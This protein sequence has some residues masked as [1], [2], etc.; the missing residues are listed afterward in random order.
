MRPAAEKE[1]LSS[2]PF[3][4]GQS[5]SLKRHLTCPPPARVSETEI[6]G[7]SA[8]GPAEIPAFLSHAML[9]RTSAS[10]L[11]LGL[12]A[13]L[14]A[15]SSEK[16]EDAPD[17]SLP[18]LVLP[19]GGC[20]PRALCPDEFECG[21][22]DDGCGGKLSCG[23]CGG[24]RECSEH[25]CSECV[26][27]TTCESEGR[28]CGKLT[29]ECGDT[30]D[31]GGCDTGE[32]CSGSG[33]ACE[34]CTPLECGSL[35]A[36]VC[37]EMDDGCGGTISCGCQANYRCEDSACE[38][39]PDYGCADFGAECGAVD[40]GCSREPLFCGECTEDG[41]SCVNNK[42]VFCT[43]GTAQERCALAGAQCG[44]VSDGCGGT[45]DCG[46]CGA[47]DSCVNGACICVPVTCEEQG[48]TCGE[49]YDG[50]GNFIQCGPACADAENTVVRL[51]TGNITSGNHQ[52]YDEGHG[53]R[54]FRGLKP[55]IALVQEFNF[56]SCSA[57]DLRQMVIQGFGERF[58][59][60]V[61][62]RSDVVTIPNG[63]VSYY[64]IKS[65]GILKD[66]TLDE[67]DHVWA[68]IDIPGKA[69]LWA[70]SIHFS[71]KS[72]K[73]QK[74]IADLVERLGELGIPKG[75]FVAVGGD[76]NTASRTQ[77]KGLAFLDNTG[78]IVLDTDDDCPIDQSGN[79]NTNGS[80][81]KDYDAIYTSQNLKDLQTPVIISGAQNLT[82][83]GLVF[84]SRVFTP[85]S[86]VAPVKKNDSGASNVQ[87]MAVVKDYAIPR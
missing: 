87:H 80:R 56:G 45:V 77:D 35:P 85:L 81:Q 43:P 44:T 14:A 58:F 75:D 64:P 63:I 41:Q 25:V 73:R 61:Q 18:P 12:C 65:W 55:Q 86:A 62:S 74:S 67:R 24:I 26:P 17:A 79:D 51:V 13:F 84:D 15:C 71:T 69:D 33:D 52:S 3:T 54:I 50:C 36:E 47:P 10:L 78:L 70:V 82:E 4:A 48:V 49:A 16:T 57:R 83:R 31:C 60:V 27:V 29:D 40:E 9:S 76:F 59:H 28:V 42:C 5:L 32:K 68:R 46:L 72:E 1:D 23:T 7:R 2:A 8:A 34:P 66:I 30:V 22:M 6:F 53:L 38:L 37:G 21:E 39:C 19:D 11:A 20:V